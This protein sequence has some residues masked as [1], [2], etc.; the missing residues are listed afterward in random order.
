MGVGLSSAWKAVRT[1]LEPE[2]RRKV[3][4]GRRRSGGSAPAFL[5]AYNITPGRK[6][7]K[8]RSHLDK[9]VTESSTPM[10]HYGRKRKQKDHGSKIAID[11]L[12]ENSSRS[13]L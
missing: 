7:M 2:E 11:V 12:Q 6:I 4:I 1:V 13:L 5:F 8:S 3:R 10:H 9:I